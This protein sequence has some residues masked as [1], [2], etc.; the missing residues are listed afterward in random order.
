LEETGQGPSEASSGETLG[1]PVRRLALIVEYDGT[2]YRGFQVQVDQPTIQGAIEQ[3]LTAFTREQIRIRGASRTDSG[4]HAMGQVVDFLTQASYPVGKFPRA[5]NYHLPPDI[6]VQAAFEVNPNFH[7]RKNA[8][9]RMYRYRILNRAWQSPLGRYT[10]HWVREKLNTDAMYQAAQHLVGVHDF[11][12]LALSHPIEKSAAR[13]VMRWDVRREQETIIIECEATGFLKH[14]IRRA[15][16]ILVEVGKGKW[17]AS[18][19]KD[20]LDNKLPEG[21]VWPSLP[22]RG[23]C[24][25]KVTYTDFWDKVKATNETD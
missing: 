11:R 19:V 1:Q 9:S 5:L 2:K 13:Q 25:I 8:A 22:A 7:S 15:N 21:L 12:P 18:I 10:E 23:L 16:A 20:T 6:K 4:A 14:Q 3:A 17:P 24:L